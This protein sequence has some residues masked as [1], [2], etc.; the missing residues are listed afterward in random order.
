M[1]IRKINDALSVQKSPNLQI[2]SEMLLVSHFA[3]LCGQLYVVGECYASSQ[4]HDEQTFAP[5]HKQQ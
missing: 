2:I 4:S 5:V 1:S 3:I